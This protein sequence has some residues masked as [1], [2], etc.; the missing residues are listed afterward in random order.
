[1]NTTRP[2]RKV[3]LTLTGLVVLPIIGLTTLAS[4]G[5]LAGHF[6]F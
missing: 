4:L 2:L 6:F 3:P 1:M 5:Y